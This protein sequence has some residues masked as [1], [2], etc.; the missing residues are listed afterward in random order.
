MSWSNTQNTANSTHFIEAEQYSQFILENLHDGLLPGNFYRDVSD[1]GNGTN[2]NIKTIGTVTIQETEELTPLTYNPID[3]GEVS[4][5]ITDY[6]GDAWAVSD[7]LRQDGSQIEQLMASRAQEGTRSLQEY[8]ETRF[9][10]VANQGLTSG[11]L[12]EVNGFP[13]R[14]V[15][16]GVDAADAPNQTISLGDIIKAKLSF[17]KA[18][19]PASGRV[20]IVDPVVAATMDTK[21][22]ASFAVDRNPEFMA[23]LGSGFAREHQFV[24]NLFGFTVITS[25]RLPRI[26]SETID[27]DTVEDGVANIAMCIA[28]DNCKPVMHAWRQ[29]PMTESERNKDLRQDEFVTTARFGFG[30]QRKDTL[31]AILTSA[32]TY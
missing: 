23:A 5:S 2:L 7:V 12:N 16:S 4:L 14:Y 15:G 20:L 13:H 24:M 1:F 8:H 17:D 11:E 25:N 28:D 22:S 32:V 30:V 18:N 31:L 26:E 10:E 27:G 29:Q 6:V 19:V 9:L 21:F 3:T